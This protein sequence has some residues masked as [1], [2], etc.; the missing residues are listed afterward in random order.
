MNRHRH[1]IAASAALML[2]LAV[3]CGGKGNP[4]APASGAGGSNTGSSGATGAGVAPGTALFTQSPIDV[5][6][7]SSIVP[8]GNLNPPDHTLPTNHAYFFHP[9]AANA[10]VRAP[11]AGTVGTITRGAD[12]GDDQLIVT[13][14]PGF[15][16][17]LAHIRLDAGV[18][19][20]ARLTAGQRLG[21]TAS[22]AGAMDLGIINNAVTLF[23]ARPE[24]YI[25]GTLHGDSPLKY[26]ADPVK[27][28]LYA[29]VA[30][31][32][33]DKDGQI[34]FDQAGRLAGNWFAP[35][36][37]PVSATENF[38]NG[39]KHL[40]FV[41]DVTDPSRVRISI[42]GTLSIAGAYYVQSGATDPA[43]V[44]TSSG[45][46]AYQ[47]FIV[48]QAQLPAAMMMV[49]LLAEDRIR[50]EAFPA[51]TPLTTEFTGAALPYIR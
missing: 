46:V 36:L 42:G 31:S 39:P 23:F 2:V 50:V 34:N 16:Y 18:A 29:K 9:S 44:S 19:Q 4:T 51:G 47:L 48:P 10:D 11:A 28:D 33:G 12:G 1:V 30:R 32:G 45:R 5:S 15:D 35:D 38:G 24:R 21:V 41:R 27:A 22:A 40:A 49:Q 26:F 20:G 7:I 43:D 17:Y 6:V 8:I 37:L 14:A 13:A 25:P 3:A